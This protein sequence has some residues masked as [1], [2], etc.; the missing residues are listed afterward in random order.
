MTR[1]NDTLSVEVDPAQVGF[2]SDRLGRIDAL[3]QRYVDDG[4]LPGWSVLVTR[5]GQP[6]HISRGGL[7]DVEAGTPVELDTI[8]RIFSMTKP[9]T[10]VAA[11]MLYEQGAFEL[12]DPIARWLPEFADMRVWDGGSDLKPKTVPA[13]EPIRIWHLL[14]H[15]SGLTYG[16]HHAHPVDAL[17]RA[18]GYE[19]GAPPSVDLAGASGAFASMPLLFHPGREWNYSVSTDVLGRLVEVV[20]GQPLDAFFTEH[21]FSPLGMTDTGFGGADPA[22]T[23][24]LYTPGLMR[25][26]LLGDSV[27][28]PT[29]FSGGGGL[30]STLADYHRFTQLLRGRGRLGDVRLLGDRTVRYMASNHL[31]G[32]ADLV[33]FGR[34]LFAE[35]PFDGVGFGLGFSVTLDPA[36]THTLCSRGEFAW[37][38]A[39]STAFWVDPVEDITAVFM[40]QLLPSSTYPVRSQLR[41]L[42]YSALT[43]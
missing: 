25:A 19:W 16:F 33:T 1:P 36:A 37:G 27:L 20:S 14:T 6:V 41:Q 38:G 9:V 24:A 7:R 10:S 12:N 29:W 2:D 11:M 34:P 4:H 32:G 26:D 21:I 3:L 22:R 28:R 5:H 17:Y 31:P 8:F 23:A 30:T 13:L 43:A 15:T 40:T 18:A 35:T 42:V 39:A